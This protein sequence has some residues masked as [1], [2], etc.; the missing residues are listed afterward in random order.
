MRGGFYTVSINTAG[1]ADKTTT[2]ITI[3]TMIAMI[4]VRVDTSVGGLVMAV[5]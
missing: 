4:L 3:V 2:T 5:I 1:N